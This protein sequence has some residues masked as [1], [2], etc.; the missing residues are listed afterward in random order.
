MRQRLRTG[1]LALLALASTRA[2]VA[3]QPAPAAKAALPPGPEALKQVLAT[4]NGEPITRG[5]FVD[6]L[7]RYPVPPGNEKELY[8]QVVDY[9]AQ[10][11]LL[12]QFLVKMKIAVTDEEIDEAVASEEAQMKAEQNR[13]L[14]TVLAEEGRDLN[15]L[16]AQITP[17]VAWDKYL[18]AVATDAE[19]KKFIDRNKDVFSRTQVRA[20]HIFLAAP[21]DAPSAAKEAARQKL[22]AIKAEIDAGKIGFADAANKYTED[23]IN[24]QAPN[25]GDLGYFQRKGQFLDSFAA[26]AF[27][28]QPGQISEPFE[29]EYGVHLIQV[30]DRKP[31]EPFDPEQNRAFVLNQYRAD[32]MERII[33]QEKKAAKIDVKPMPADLFPPAAA[34]PPAGAPATAPA[35]KGAAPANPAAPR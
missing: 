2:A 15:W 20:S 25:G 21:A 31:G 22:L 33:N 32:L 26:K 18:A 30:T 16:R 14:K 24:K 1:L 17:R 4:V 7:S 13:D 23:D 12:D 11:K 19:L 29:T 28:M 34:Q 10:R 3:Q 5:E 9:L 6:F 8:Q 35:A 27:S